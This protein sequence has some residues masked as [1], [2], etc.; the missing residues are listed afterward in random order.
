MRDAAWI[1]LLVLSALA[2]GKDDHPSSSAAKPR[3]DLQR[4]QEQRR[5]EQARARQTRLEA[6]RAKRDAAGKRLQELEQAYK[7]LIKANDAKRKQLENIPKLRRRFVA[8]LQD[9]NVESSKLRSMEK[10]F[11]QLRKLA[12]S[13]ITGE[14]RKLRAQQQ[15]LEK[16]YEEVHSGWLRDLEEADQ[17]L[18]EE[19]PVKRDLDTLR[20]LKAR[21]LDASQLARAGRAGSRERGIIN[22][23]FRNWLGQVPARKALAVRILAAYPST[24]GKT[25]DTYDFTNLDFYILLEMFENGLDR[26]NIAVEKKVLTA[27]YA[28][29][30]AIQAQLDDLREKIAQKMQEGGGE[31]EEFDD[32]EHRLPGQR[33]KVAGLD[34]AATQYGRIFNEAE[35]KSDALDKAEDEADQAV[36]KAKQEL[37]DTRSALRAF[38]DG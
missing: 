3:A 18:V 32:L 23:G 26:R 8:L 9:R 35:A 37:R 14:L 38:E 22:D 5:Q 36:K 6:L 21:W 16:R 24:K 2:C 29:L 17:H 28:K 27:N 11:A 15:A 1:T 12:E 25:P 4:R 7:A 31:L 20:K 33:S 30:E 13:R 19:S 10:H 34:A